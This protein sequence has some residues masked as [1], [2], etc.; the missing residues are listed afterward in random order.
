MSKLTLQLLLFYLC[1]VTGTLWAANDP[2]VGKWKVNPSKSKP[3]DQMKVE[4][5]GANRYT[6]TFAPG[7][8]DTVVANG[9]DQPGLRGT[10]FSITLE[11]PNN[12]KVIRKNRLLLRCQSRWHSYGDS[13]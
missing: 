8:A 11:G 10:T 2:F 13:P 7:A 6:I 12:W 1:L 5:V 9:S 4:V 3:T